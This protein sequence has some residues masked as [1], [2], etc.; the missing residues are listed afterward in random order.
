M[1]EGAALEMLFRGD[2]NEGSNPSLS[3]P[4]HLLAANHPSNKPS[5]ELTTS[6][7]D[8]SIEL[9]YSPS[10]LSI[11]IATSHQAQANTRT[12][13]IDIVTAT[14]A[15]QDREPCQKLSIDSANVQAIDPL[16]AAAIGA[17]IIFRSGEHTAIETT[18]ILTR[19]TTP[20]TTAASL[21]SQPC[22]KQSKKI[23]SKLPQGMCPGCQFLLFL[24]S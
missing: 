11:E 10:C 9:V 23:A 4:Y 19:N 8:M 6:I 18:G 12:R 1:V 14:I 15:N 17:V 5:Q 22:T 7:S 3:V 13:N 21:K 20:T 2:F 24:I 16:Q